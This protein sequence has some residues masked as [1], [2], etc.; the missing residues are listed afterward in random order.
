MEATGIGRYPSKS[1]DSVWAASAGRNITDQG[2][3]CRAS[4]NC[5]TVLS[6]GVG[7]RSA[8]ET[9]QVQSLAA[10]QNQRMPPGRYSE[11]AVRR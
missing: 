4:S 5:L 10:I 7:E 11:S 1:N 9:R 6:Q 2:G 8:R 3:G